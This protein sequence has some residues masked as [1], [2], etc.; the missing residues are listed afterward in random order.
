ME[1]HVHG[2]FG[3]D[4]TLYIVREAAFGREKKEKAVKTSV[5]LDGTITPSKTVEMGYLEAI[6]SLIK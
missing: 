5:E 3:L 4:I 2:G 6:R 1:G